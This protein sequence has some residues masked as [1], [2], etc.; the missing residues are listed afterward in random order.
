MSKSMIAALFLPSS[1]SVLAKEKTTVDMVMELKKARGD[2]L[3]KP[4]KMVKNHFHGNK[5][6]ETKISDNQGSKD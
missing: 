4:W 5:V 6:K 1:L 2:T 3:P